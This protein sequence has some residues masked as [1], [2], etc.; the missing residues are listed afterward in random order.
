[1]R[2][3]V[4][5]ALICVVAVVTVLGIQSFLT[6]ESS[7]ISMGFRNSGLPENVEL[8]FRNSGLPENVELG[9]ENSG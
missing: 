5:I 4:I 8:G 3:L 7:S 1:M 6:N 9:F 2:K